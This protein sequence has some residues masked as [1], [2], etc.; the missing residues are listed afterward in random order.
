MAPVNKNMYAVL[1]GNECFYSCSF[2]PPAGLVDWLT[3]GLIVADS[4]ELVNSASWL[5]RSDEKVAP[6]PRK[7]VELVRYDGSLDGCTPIVSRQMT[8]QTVRI[9]G[10]DGEERLFESKICIPG[11]PCAISMKNG[12]MQSLMPDSSVVMAGFAVMDGAC[13]AWLADVWGQDNGGDPRK[14]IF[15]WVLHTSC[16]VTTGA[17][18]VVGA[19]TR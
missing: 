16:R 17:I 1:P 10:L 14:G 13:P 9:M 19:I 11:L 12:R 6:S 4:S 15:M 18:A 8:V 2:E 7:A 5:F 3:G